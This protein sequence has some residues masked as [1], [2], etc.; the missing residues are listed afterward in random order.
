M[1]KKEEHALLNSGK[2]LLSGSLPTPSWKTA[3]WE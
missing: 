2:E 1:M 3:G